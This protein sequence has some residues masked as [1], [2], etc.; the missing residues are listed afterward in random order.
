MFARA[1]L[2]FGLAFVF[3]MALTACQTLG[4][5]DDQPNPERLA[6]KVINAMGGRKALDEMRFLGFD[7][8]VRQGAQTQTRRSHLW[9]RYEGRC[10]VEATVD[11]TPMIYLFN[12][13][14]LSSGTVFEGA[15][16]GGRP[17]T[18]EEIQRAYAW[19]I[20]DTY[21]L[22]SATKLL[23]PGTNLRYDGEY[24]I[25]NVNCPTLELSFDPGVGLTP[26]DR[27]WFHLDP[28]TWR[29]RAWSF[30]LKGKDVPPTVA[31]WSRWE[32]AG[33]L[34]LPVQFDLAGNDRSIQM[35]RLFVYGQVDDRLFEQRASGVM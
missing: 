14:D 30:V 5:G 6:K 29:P 17:A 9:D 3:S 24:T 7:F 28:E 21:W 11:D 26:Q 25:E 22:L 16:G 18:P 31:Y 32:P 12:T 23:D 1:M 19:H 4:L 27:Y 20:N 13:N 10:R 2:T 8:V 33:D 34:L 35:E 15:R